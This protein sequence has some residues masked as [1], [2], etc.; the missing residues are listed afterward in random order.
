MPM[1]PRAW[2]EEVAAE[3]AKKALGLDR[4][5]ERT[6]IVKLVN[7]KNDPQRIAGAVGFS[8]R[9]NTVFVYKAKD[10]EALERA[11]P[12]REG[13]AFLRLGMPGERVLPLRAAKGVARDYWTLVGLWRKGGEG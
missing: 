8:V 2:A 4:I 11:F 1:A 5:Q 13:W 7:D 12:D 10:L 6:F 3:A 9:D